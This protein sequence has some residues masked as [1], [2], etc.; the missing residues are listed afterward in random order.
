MLN[1]MLINIMVLSSSV[2]M[3]L[4]YVTLALLTL[5]LLI[6]YLTSVVHATWDLSS[7]YAEERRL[8]CL[9]KK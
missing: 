9:M 5:E 8:T 7:W 6:T 2:M 3:T 4:M 1:G